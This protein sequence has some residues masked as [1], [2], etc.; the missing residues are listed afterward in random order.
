M[1]LEWEVLPHPVYSPNIAPTDY[2]LFKSLQ[3]TFD[4]LNF[5]NIEDLKKCIDNFLTSTLSSDP[6]LSG[7]WQKVIETH[8]Q[9]SQEE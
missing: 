6:E 7:R 1:E 9:Y 5:R 4:G 2:H 3:H 8:G